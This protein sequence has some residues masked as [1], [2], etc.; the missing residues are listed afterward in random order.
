VPV[1]SVFT[2]AVVLTLAVVAGGRA[3]DKPKPP[4]TPAEKWKA[5][6]KEDTDARQEVRKKLDEIGRGE[7]AATK[8]EAILKEYAAA[9]G[10]RKEAA[11]ALVR[12]DP[13]SA[14]A[15]EVLVWVAT[16]AD[17]DTRKV[18]VEL[19]AK[20]HAANPK[21]GEVVIRLGQAERYDEGGENKALTALL[22]SAE[23]STDATVGGRAAIVKAWRAL[24]LSQKADV[25]KNPKA[26][27]L[28]AAA[29]KALEAA[30]KG[31]DKVKVYDFEK[32][33][34]VGETAAGELF[35]LRNLRVGKPAPEIE[36]EDLDGKK[37]RLSDY[38]GKVVMLDFWGDW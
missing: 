24:K 1:R 18:A 26:D 25:E 34:T 23:K 10:K 7:E 28:A 29:E 20:H 36:G 11:L 21:I 16:R 17:G 13:S 15:G 38:K 2:S 9:G 37:F 5:I 14:L 12:G 22:A 35:E 32:S 27:E 8:R 6:Q 4:D 30:A 3:D 19:L 33:P 31:F